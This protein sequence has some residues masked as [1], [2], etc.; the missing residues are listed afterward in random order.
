GRIRRLS[1]YQNL[2]DA[3][4]LAL[5]FPLNEAQEVIALE[6]GYTNWA[7]LKQDL[8]RVSGA[9]ADRAAP[10]PTKLTKAIPV[11]YV[12]DA[13]ASAAFYRDQLG[14]AIEFLHGQPPFY[15]SVSRDEA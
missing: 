2:T 15:A 4:A 6:Q 3:E 8:R 13:Q 12:S 10:V 5:P 9:G 1:R 7:E 11:L 14:F